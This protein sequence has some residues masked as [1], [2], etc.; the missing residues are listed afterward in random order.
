MNIA[1]LSILF[2]ELAFQPFRP[3]PHIN[4]QKFSKWAQRLHRTENI[5][6]SKYIFIQ[7]KTVTYVIS[8]VVCL[9]HFCTAEAHIILRI[10]TLFGKAHC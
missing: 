5:N 6:F 1:E 3:R 2:V 7:K 8:F 10:F 4:F 9:S